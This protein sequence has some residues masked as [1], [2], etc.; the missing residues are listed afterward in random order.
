M[1]KKD[2][3]LNFVLLPLVKE[4]GAQPRSESIIRNKKVVKNPIHK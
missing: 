3:T 2:Y 4:K 1:K